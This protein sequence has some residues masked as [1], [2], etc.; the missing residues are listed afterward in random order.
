MNK[1]FTLI[2]L[3]ITIAIIA[4][5]A[6]MLLPALTKAKS[7]ALL[8]SCVNQLHQCGIALEL[9]AADHEDQIPNISGNYMRT[10]INIIR[11]YGNLPFGL[12]RLIGDY[13]MTPQQ[14]GCPAHDPMTPYA[15]EQSWQKTGAVMSGYLYRETDAGFERKKSAMENATKAIV[16]DFSYRNSTLSQSAHSF[17]WTNLLFNDGHVLTKPN[18]S[19]P[20]NPFTATGNTGAMTPP[21]CDTIWH[22]ADRVN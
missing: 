6:S 20:E 15:V 4:I 10:S 5:L 7:K 21:D 1:K 13:G 9:Y 12:G 14:F 16:M 11:M 8:A 18:T 17:R 3:L 22:N 2:E 19:T